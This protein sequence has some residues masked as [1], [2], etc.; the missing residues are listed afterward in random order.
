MGAQVLE[1]RGPLPP[2]APSTDATRKIVSR[3]LLD[4]LR[5]E[6]AVVQLAQKLPEGWETKGLGGTAAVMLGKA[7]DAALD[8]LEALPLQEFSAGGGGE[9]L[10]KETGAAS[11]IKAHAP[12]PKLCTRVPQTTHPSP[13]HCVPHWALCPCPLCTH[14]PVKTLHL[15]A[16]P[17]GQQ[18]SLS[19]RAEGYPVF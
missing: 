14:F 4:N 10:P 7:V 15:Q 17:E 18:R 12:C 9:Q 11:G 5:H 8:K 3:W 16:R 2:G 1:R 13:T 6:E 19:A